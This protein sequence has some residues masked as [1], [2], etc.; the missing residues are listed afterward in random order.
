MSKI[1]RADSK[2]RF[3]TG[4][5]PTQ[6]DFENL[7][8]S[9]VHKDDTI[10]LEQVGTNGATVVSLLNQKANSSHTHEIAD[11]NGLQA[12]INK[13]NTF[14]DTVDASDDTINRWQEVEAFLQGITDTETLTG[15]L[16]ALKS[17]I[18]GDLSIDATLSS[19]SEHALQNKV[20]YDEL[21]I[22]EGS[23]A[24][25]T[26]TYT[27]DDAD[28]ITFNV[29][30]LDASQFDTISTNGKTI[31]LLPEMDVLIRKDKAYSIINCTADM[32][33]ASTTAEHE[34]DGGILIKFDTVP[35]FCDADGNSAS[36][37]NPTSKNGE[38]LRCSF[39]IPKTV[40]GTQTFTVLASNA[41][42]SIGEPYG[43]IT[44]NGGGNSTVKSLKQKIAELEARLAAVPSNYIEFATDMSAYASAPTGKIVAYFGTTTNDFRRGLFYEKTAS[45]WQNIPVSPVIQ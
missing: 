22:T 42:Y 45:G 13:V 38:W 6:A 11:V 7:H 15:L 5:Y 16:A 21:R 8:D 25:E 43:S 34:D 19:T 10:P 3:R 4:M 14:L 23:S 35:H 1:S 2:A 12:F 41:D 27:D 17:E 39:P 31:T 24:A 30:V 33:L 40:G 20:L 44:S 9:Y 26:I 18:D 29:Q 37:D 28:T 36:I 32:I